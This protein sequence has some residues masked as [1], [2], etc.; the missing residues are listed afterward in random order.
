MFF[1]FFSNAGAQDKAS[2]ELYLQVVMFGPL[3]PHGHNILS[4]ACEIFF[5]EMFQLKYNLNKLHQNI[6]EYH[7]MGKN[8]MRGSCF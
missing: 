5:Q 4:L 3:L 1:F 8:G 2:N 7:V 6:H